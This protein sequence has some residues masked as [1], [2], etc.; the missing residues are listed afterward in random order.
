M[1]KMKLKKA[2]CE[3]GKWFYPHEIVQHSYKCAK[4]YKR[5]G[6]QIIGARLEKE[7]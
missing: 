5:F 4:F 2:Q 3:C 1:E 6:K 7:K